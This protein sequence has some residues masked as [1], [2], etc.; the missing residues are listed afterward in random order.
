MQHRILAA[1]AIVAGLAA[2]P[3]SAQS[4][5]PNKP[6]RLIAPEVREAVEGVPEHPGAIVGGDNHRDGRSS[7]CLSA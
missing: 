6:I 7:Y 2:S 1:V 3:A 4:S 5:Y